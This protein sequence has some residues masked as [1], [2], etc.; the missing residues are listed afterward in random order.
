M[1]K[2]I[3]TLGL[4]LIAMLAAVPGHGQWTSQFQF[5]GIY[6]SIYLSPQDTPTPFTPEGND[7]SFISTLTLLMNVSLDDQLSAFATVETLRGLSIS[8]YA[9]GINWQP[10][11]SPL[12]QL[13]A[14]KFM[15]PFGN[16]LERR[17]ASTNP[18][19]GLPILYD[20]LHD[21]SAFD[22]P[23]NNAELLLIRGK[24]LSLQYPDLGHSSAQTAQATGG[25]RI[26]SGHLPKPGRGMRILSREL[27]LTGLELFGWAKHW[28]Y[29]VAVTNGAL[30]NPADRNPNGGVNLMGRFVLLPTT[31]LVLGVSVARGAYLNKSAVAEK[32]A[33]IG[34][35][36]RDVKQISA[37]ADVMFSYR[38]L[39]AWAEYLWNRYQSPFLPQNLDLQGWS[40]EAKYKFSARVYG[41]AR[42]NA[43]R[44]GRIADTLDVDGDGQLME[45][46]DFNV[47]QLEVA[48]GLRLNRNSYLKLSHQFNRSFNVP[49]GDPADDINAFQIVVFF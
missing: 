15:A 6:N 22:V 29:A 1:S 31:G 4:A 44:F 36:A 48:L 25:E 26:L 9:M 2:T 24:G 3:W 8:I 33:A 18:L 10:G 40:I 46:W 13:R 23:E 34:K 19:I 21:L 27:Y 16:F 45:P 39:D 37:G 38:H 42:F 35:K 5:G 12:L 7:P 30:S 43:L 32:L 47:S 17:Y 20:Y 11:P 49:Q 41:A 14:G 28:R